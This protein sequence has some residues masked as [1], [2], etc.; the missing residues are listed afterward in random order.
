MRPHHRFWPT[1][2]PHQIQV[3]ATSLWDNLEFQARRFPD[4]TAIV[5]FGCEISYRELVHQAEQIG[6]AHV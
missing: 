1:R 3:P 5:F 2:L 4:K 6:R